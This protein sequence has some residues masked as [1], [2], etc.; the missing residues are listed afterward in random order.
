MAARTVKL[1][2][3]AALLYQSETTLSSAPLLLL[4]T[5]F[6]PTSNVAQFQTTGPPSRI[7]IP[8]VDGTSLATDISVSSLAQKDKEKALSNSTVHSRAVT[9]K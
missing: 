7:L 2:S 5:E 4:A 3:I 6:P 1:L 8:E 9:E